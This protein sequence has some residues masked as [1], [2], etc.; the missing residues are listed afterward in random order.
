MSGDVPK[1]RPQLARPLTALKISEADL[2]RQAPLRANDP[3]PLVLQATSE[4]SLSSWLHSQRD[5]LMSALT[6]HGGLLFR[7]FDVD[8]PDKFAAAA[9]ALTP[10]LLG[11]LERA[12]A[13]TEVA[14]SVFTSTELAADQVIPPHHKM[15]YS[16]NSPLRMV[17]L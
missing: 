6:E 14:P 15:S 9:R 12:A 13:R 5:R 1:A 11:Y 4:V 8:S 10:D 7:G 2:V 17:S 3:L 16:H